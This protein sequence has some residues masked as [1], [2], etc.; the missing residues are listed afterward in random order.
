MAKLKIDQPQ[1]IFLYNKAMGGVD[2][3]DQNINSYMIGHRSQKWWWPVFRF[4]FDLSVNKAY[5]PYRQEKRCVGEC[6]LDLL[7]FR[8]SIVDTHYRCPLK[9]TTTNIL[10]P[11]RKLS[12]VTNEV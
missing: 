2:C 10:P 8:Q 4:H 9:S 12:K 5:Q 6:K 3:L 11:T 1:S 7:E